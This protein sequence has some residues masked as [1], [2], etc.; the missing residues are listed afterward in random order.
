MS[1]E[2]FEARLNR[3]LLE[4]VQRTWDA[5]ATEFVSYWEE[6]YANQGCETCGPDYEYT[7]YIL[8]E[9]PKAPDDPRWGRRPRLYSYRGKFG[10]LMREL[11]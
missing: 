9:T 10:D 11:T 4:Y 3:A 2:T 1:E 8:V 7:V 6:V 5:E